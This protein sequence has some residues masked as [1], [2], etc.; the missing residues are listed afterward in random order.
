MKTN[1]GNME[2]LCRSHPN[3]DLWFEDSGDLFEKRLGS[4]NPNKKFKER[5]ENML[6]AIA[7]CN[8][9]P[10]SSECLSEGM[11]ESNLDYGIWGGTLP[12]ERI[13]LANTAKAST[14]RKARMTTAINIRSLIK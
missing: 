11:K 1:G 5:V 2:G 7:I 9:C 4:K 14:D 6:E 8:K 3:P 12:G 10:I 13:A